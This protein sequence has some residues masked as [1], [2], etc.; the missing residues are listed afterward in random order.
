MRDCKIW[1]DSPRARG[2]FNNQTV[3]SQV[4]QDIIKRE[5]RRATGSDALNAKCNLL[6][7][8]LKDMFSIEELSYMTY[9]RLVALLEH[10]YTRALNKMNK[11][12]SK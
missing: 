6:Y 7:A 8:N 12:G 1:F 9:S 5:M 10:E 11:G 2:K 3:S 4:L